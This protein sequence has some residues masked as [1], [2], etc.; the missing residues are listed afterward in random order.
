MKD[1]KAVGFISTTDAARARGFYG[2]VLGLEITEDA[3]AIVAKVGDALVR[4]TTLPDFKAGEHPV[5]GFSVPDADAAV[6]D[7]GAK[8]VAFILYEFLGEAQ[9]PN[10]IWTGPDGAK[11]AWFKDPDGNLLSVT[12]S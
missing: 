9:E 7:L 6:L 4:I 10:G 2:D 3:Y 12:S 1:A 11:V 8:G 5:F